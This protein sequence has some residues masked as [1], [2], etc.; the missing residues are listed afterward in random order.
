MDAS[1]LLALKWS[2]NHLTSKEKGHKG[3]PA[4]SWWLGVGTISPPCVSQIGLFALLSS[5]E[6]SP[7]QLCDNR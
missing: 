4:P 6:S 3:P 2:L 7:R 1:Q 5:N